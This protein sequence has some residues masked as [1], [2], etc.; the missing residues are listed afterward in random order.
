MSNSQAN[1]ITNVIT[2]ASSNPKVSSGNYFED[3]RLGQVIDHATPRTIGEGEVALYI[4]LTGARQILHSAEPVAQSL[5]YKDRPVDDLLAFHIAFGN[6]VTDISVNA[7][8][9]L[10]YADVRFLHPVYIG[11]TL[12]TRSTVIGLRQNSNGKSGVVYVRSVA[13][14]QL[15]QPVLSWVRWVMVHKNKLDAPAPE[16]SIP[17]LPSFVAAEELSVP[18]FL[19]ARKFD[20]STTGSEYLWD[21]YIV[22]ERINHPAG[23][24]I[25]DSDHT[26]ATKLYQNNARL[27]FDD[28]MMK[29][30]AFGRRLV[31][32][33]HVISLCRALSHDGLENALTIAAINAG[34]HC[35][36]TFGDD[37]IY[38]WTEVLDKWAIPGR[39]DIAA[40]RLRMVGVKNIPAETLASTHI[41]NDG[42]QT[43][44]PNVV[45]DLDYTVL[46]PRRQG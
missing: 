44:H 5:G 29:Q 39:N 10:G 12:S 40:L 17:N 35:N 24:T 7:V 21:D 46:M 16:T 13:I 22:G 23:M 3:F 43:Y 26:L 9:N 38:T 19:N 27:H 20:T 42:K 41:E 18:S 15:L 32:G 2:K 11:D 6:T 30:T 37:T 36:P 28:V 33:G 31:Y 1:V 14:N 45:L 25:S 34:T 8:A 4:A